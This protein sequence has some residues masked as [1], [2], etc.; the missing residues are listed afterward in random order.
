MGSLMSGTVEEPGEGGPWSHLVWGHQPPPPHSRMLCPVSLVV[1]ELGRR[2]RFTNASYSPPPHAGAPPPPP[3]LGQ[4]CNA[5]SGFSC[6]DD[7][8]REIHE[9]GRR[10]R[11]RTTAPRP[12]RRRRP[13]LSSALSSFACFDHSNREI[14]EQGR[15]LRFT[16]AG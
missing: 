3:P 15:R 7:N 10:L 6:F 4:L 16:N 12:S 11:S 14:H 9:Q 8:R 5:L 2:L 13:R 1:H